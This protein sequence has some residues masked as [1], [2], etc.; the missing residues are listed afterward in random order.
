MRHLLISMDG[1]SSAQ[2]LAKTVNVLDAI[3]WLKS[4]WSEVKEE[5][6]QKC[7]K[8]CG[9]GGEL[10]PNFAQRLKFRKL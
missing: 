4:A 6:I 2:E 1:A 8:H 10:I 5:T 9:F 3:L 7:F